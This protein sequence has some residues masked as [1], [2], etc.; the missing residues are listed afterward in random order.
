M[1]FRATSISALL[2]LGALSAC[3]A[4]ELVD[5]AKQE[6]QDA[7]DGAVE[8]QLA[9]YLSANTS[10]SASE[11]DCVSAEIVAELGASTV[12][13]LIIDTGG[14]FTKVSAEDR[15]RVQAA[16]RGAASACG[17]AEFSLA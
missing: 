5:D 12:A 8:S 10:L 1:N 15:Q 13:R 4:D 6:V 9:A 16:A 2:A 7:A 11:A 3:G 14:D 17:I